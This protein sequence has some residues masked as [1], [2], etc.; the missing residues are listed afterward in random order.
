MRGNTTRFI[1]LFRF[2]Y[3]WSLCSCL[4]EIY[5]TDYKRIT[6]QCIFHINKRNNLKRDIK[7]RQEAKV[8]HFVDLTKIHMIIVNIE[9]K[10]CQQII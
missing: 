7:N 4:L 6:C 1:E 9:K 8:V 2:H 3:K 5:I 10:L